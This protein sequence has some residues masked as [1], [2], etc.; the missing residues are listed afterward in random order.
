[1]EGGFVTVEAGGVAS[2]TIVSSRGILAISAPNALQRAAVVSGSVVSGGGT[3]ELGSFGD[4]SAVAS[5]LTVAS[6]GT[7]YF[8]EF[9]SLVWNAGGPNVVDGVTI[10][11]GGFAHVTIASPTA[12]TGLVG[13]GSISGFV[14]GPGMR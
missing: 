1:M 10:Q 3:V 14:D 2:N 9:G 7:I 8:T 6:G 11:N 13:S 4:S 12:P 5:G